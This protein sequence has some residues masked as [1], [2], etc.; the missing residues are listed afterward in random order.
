MNRFDRRRQALA[1]GLAGLAGY[2][3]AVGFLSARG[4][5]VSFM[6]GNTTRLGVNLARDPA[7]AMVPT[8]LIAGFIAGVAAGTVVAARAGAR[9]KPAVL[10][11]VCT[12]VLGAALGNA[13]GAGPVVPAL[14]VVAMGALNNTFQRGGDVAVGLTYMTGALVKLGQAL[15]A[16]LVGERRTGWAAYLLLWSG[17]A[18]GAVLGALAWSH[19]AGAALWAA[20]AWGLAMIGLALRLPVEREGPARNPA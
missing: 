17:L 15:G 11:L 6:S 18:S 4:Y 9:R 13:L 19:I 14:L 1:V 3:D 16:A 10:A 7:E 20:G 5:F 2:V 8:L 12:L